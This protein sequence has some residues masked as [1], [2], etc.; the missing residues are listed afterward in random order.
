VCGGIIGY[1]A[2]PDGEGEAVLLSA[3]LFGKVLEEPEIHVDRRG[4]L[5]PKAL[6]T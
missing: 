4:P 1:K 3:K 6:V 5:R 2:E